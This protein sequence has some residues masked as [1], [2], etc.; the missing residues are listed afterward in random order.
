MTFGLNVLES[1][2][3]LL[4]LIGYPVLII[5]GLIVEAPV[6]RREPVTEARRGAAAV[7]AIISLAAAAPL[8]VMA[9][10]L[11]AF[12]VLLLGGLVVPAALT[13]VRLRR[14]PRAATDS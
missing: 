5:V 6:L 7:L 14:P 10:A 4:P 13:L 3:F 12:G 1:L 8:L 2:S 11:G 9:W